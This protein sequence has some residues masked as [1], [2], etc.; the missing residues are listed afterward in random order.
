MKRHKHIKNEKT[1]NKQSRFGT[2][3][4]KLTVEVPNKQPKILS[5]EDQV[6]K[7]EIF[8]VWIWWSQMCR[9]I[10]QILTARNM[11]RCFQIRRLQSG[12]SKTK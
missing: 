2:V 7:A 3:D 11:P 6:T 9:L 8:R 1:S 10:R 4:G 5:T 12:T